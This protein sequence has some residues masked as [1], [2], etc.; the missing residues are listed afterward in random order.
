MISKWQPGSRVRVKVEVEDIGGEFGTVEKV[1][2]AT[3]SAATS[4]VLDNDVYQLGAYFR[5]DELEEVG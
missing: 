5:D 1:S 2:Y 3:W 4:V